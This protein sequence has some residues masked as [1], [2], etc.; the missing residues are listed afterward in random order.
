MV[1]MYHDGTTF[2][3]FTRTVEFGASSISLVSNTRGTMAYKSPSS[4]S[5]STSDN[6]Y[7]MQVVGY[8]Y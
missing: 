5:V 3:S 7:I 8:K 6:I 1:A 4:G 2:N